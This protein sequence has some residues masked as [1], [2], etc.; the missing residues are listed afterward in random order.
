MMREGAKKHDRMRVFFVHLEH[1]LRSRLRVFFSG[2]TILYAYS[3]A[4]RR[5]CVCLEICT[6]EYTWDE[7]FHSDRVSICYI[8]EYLCIYK[9]VYLI[10]VFRNLYL[11]YRIVDA[12]L[13]SFSLRV[14]LTR[15]EFR[16]SFRFS[17]SFFSNGIIW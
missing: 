8:F 10:Y 2:Y 3:F 16:V 11:G 17:L 1:E 13:V 14:E 6:Y 15:P 12:P 4:Y 5:I 7:N 9:L